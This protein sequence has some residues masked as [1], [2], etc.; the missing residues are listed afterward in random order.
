M[1]TGKVTYLVFRPVEGEEKAANEGGV[2]VVFFENGVGEV[3][4]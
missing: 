2:D 3:F 4:E 1:T